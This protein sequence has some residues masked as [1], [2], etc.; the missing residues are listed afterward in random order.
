MNTVSHGPTARPLTGKGEAR[1]A[2]LLDAA[3]QSLL[4][5]G[6]A[7]TSIQRVLQQAGGSA[8]TAY[9]LF[10]NKEGLL[11]AVLQHELDG[12]RAAVFP[13]TVLEPPVDTALHELAVRLLDYALQPRSVALYRLLV[14]ECHR[15]P[16]LAEALRQAVETQIHAPLEHCLRDACERGELCI[17][18]PRRAALT[19]GNLINGIASHAR[20]SGG[21]VGGPDAEHLAACRYGVDTL[22]R[23]FRA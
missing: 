6:Y 4:E 12:L 9:Q 7:Q 5:H 16:Q 17:D 21:S 23:A 19:L 20:L 15:M 10:G 18:D 14:S 2:R 13:D 1:R 11:A 22:L 3:A 8:A